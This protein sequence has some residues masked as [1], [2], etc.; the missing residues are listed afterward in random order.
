MWKEKSVGNAKSEEMQ[1]EHPTCPVLH[2]ALITF[3]QIHIK[4]GKGEKGEIF[5]G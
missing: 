3:A 2:L 4:T 5:P 1:L